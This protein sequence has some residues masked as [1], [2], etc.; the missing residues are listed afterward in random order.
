MKKTYSHLNK[1]QIEAV[2]TTEGPV[3]VLAGAGS[4]KTSVLTHRIAHLVHDNGINPY[5][6]MAITF[7]NKAAGEMK[8]R[9]GQMIG[10]DADQLW[11]ATFHSSCCKILR[12]HAKQLKLGMKITL[13][14]MMMM[15]KKKC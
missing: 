6:I 13:L 10:N 5:N 9:I 7:T 2:K 14:F 3:L 11:M 1:K 15:I 12:K 8:A 4:G